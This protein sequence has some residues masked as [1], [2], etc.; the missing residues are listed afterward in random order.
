MLPTFGRLDSLA[1]VLIRS[2]LFG[3]MISLM[4]SLEATQPTG[5][6]IPS[7]PADRI[8]KFMETYARTGSLRAAARSARVSL[9]AHY[10]MLETSDSYRTQFQAAQQQVADRLEAECFRR[11]LAGSDELLVFLLRA[12][13]PERYREHTMV[14]H[15]GTVILAEPASSTVKGTLRFIRSE[16]EQVQ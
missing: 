7:V 4:S 13:L 5:P 12:W 2:I 6:E 8:C 3:D 14:E 10:E 16:R 11:A 15:S 9:S 1:K